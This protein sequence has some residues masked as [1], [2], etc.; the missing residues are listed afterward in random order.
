MRILKL[1]AGNFSVDLRSL[2]ITRMA[3]GILLMA[4]LFIRSRS[5]KDFYTDEGLL[6]LYALKKIYEGNYYTSVHALS[7]DYYF[8]LFLFLLAVLF[9][10]FLFIGLFTRIST[11]VSWALLI[12][13]N[14]RNPLLLHGGD[15]IFR[16]LLFWGIFTP[17]AERFSVDSYFKKRG[18][19]KNLIFSIGAFAFIL[20]ILIMY[21]FTGLLKTGDPWRKDFTAIYY[22]LSIDH[23]SYLLG[24][25]I[26]NFPQLMKGL[27]FSI[28]WFEL[29]GPLL[30]F[31]PYRNSMFR[32]IFIGLVI[33]FHMGLTLTM[34]I[35]LFP[36]F[37]MASVLILL[38]PSFWEFLPR[39]QRGLDRNFSKL[40]GGIKYYA[41]GINNWYYFRAEIPRIINSATTVL[42]IFLLVFVLLWNLKHSY[43]DTFSFMNNFKSIG[44]VFQIKQKW[45]MFAPV[46]YKA[47]GW[48]VIVGLFDNGEIVDIFRNGK[49]V[50]WDPPENRLDDYTSY[51]WRKIS[52]NV[53]KVKNKSFRR[54]YAKYLCDKWNKRENVPKLLEMDMYFVSEYTL[55]DY[56]F[57]E[58]KINK[59]Y[60]YECRIKD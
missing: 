17:W 15:I 42:I 43:K 48:Y 35:G 41:K 23:F 22:A 18:I 38:P 39:F 57:K 21:I 40:A 51:R 13:L 10:F 4:D 32:Y 56:K 20:Q 29:L 6:S 19:N 28:I 37:S 7:G 5:L 26:Y 24:P 49:E 55:P 45:N 16:C 46:P 11:I 8:Q 2:A 25:Y 33:C 58:H 59:R 34:K 1:I 52:R 14:L 27:T 36:W 9:A 30:L 50:S 31:I 44:K 47:D 3:F 53:Y 60:S 54:Y 12:S